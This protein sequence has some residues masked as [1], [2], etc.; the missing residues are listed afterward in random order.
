MALRLD[1]ATMSPPG[2]PCARVSRLPGLPARWAHENPQAKARVYALMPSAIFT[3]AGL[4]GK[5][6]LERQLQSFRRS[7]GGE[8]EGGTRREA[9]S[10]G[11]ASDDGDFLAGF[12]AALG[13]KEESLEQE[14][15]AVREQL[16]N[17]EKRISEVETAKETLIDQLHQAREE[18][19]G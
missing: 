6:R 17:A 11:E 12:R 9:S 3:V 19:A 7:R 18:V 15:Q 5:W 2:I 13:S 8:A 4:A 16:S 14:L 10:P 1:V